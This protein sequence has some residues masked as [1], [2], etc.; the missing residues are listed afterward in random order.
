MIFIMQFQWLKDIST[1]RVGCYN[2]AKSASADVKLPLQRSD[3]SSI[4]PI[5]DFF[6]F[7]A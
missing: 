1:E 3:T 7:R 5:N 6:L 4:P 2:V